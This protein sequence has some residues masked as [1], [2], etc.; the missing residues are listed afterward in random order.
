[1]DGV[2]TGEMVVD[3]VAVADSAYDRG[4]TGLIDIEEPAVAATVLV[5]VRSDG[6]IDIVAEARDVREPS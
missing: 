6:S 1:M 5:I 4:R 2:T 3:V